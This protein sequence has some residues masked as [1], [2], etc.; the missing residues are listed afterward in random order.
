[1]WMILCCIKDAI[2]G[3]TPRN[4]GILPAYFRADET[5]ALRIATLALTLQSVRRIL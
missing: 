4:A 5:S 1:M 2:A 3:V